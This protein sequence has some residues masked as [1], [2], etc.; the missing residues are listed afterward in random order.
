MREQTLQDLSLFYFLILGPSLKTFCF[1]EVN[2]KVNLKG[3]I[4]I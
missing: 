4:I 2:R 1:M 3:L